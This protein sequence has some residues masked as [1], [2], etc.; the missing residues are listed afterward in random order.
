M[1][2]TLLYA[3]LLLQATETRLLQQPPA[4]TPKPPVDWV[5]FV[6][7]PVYQPDGGLSAET[8]ALPATG[9]GLVHL[10]SRRSVCEPSASSTAEPKDAAFGWRIAS[11]ILSRTERDV[12]VSINWRRLWEDGRKVN[13]GPGSTV[14]LTLH[15]G[16]RIPL[17]HIA[18]V[19]PVPECRAVGLGLE[20]R[21]AQAAGATGVAIPAFPPDATPGGTKP[22]DAEL[23]LLHTSPSD[24]Q[25][26]FHQ[27]VRIPT[28]GGRFSF[29]P[30]TITSA[31]G[32]ASV[33]LSGSI[34]RYR[35]TTGEE[36][37]LLS[38]TRRVRGY[39]LP[40]EGVPTSTRPA[41]T[42][43]PPP[44]EVISFQ[45]PGTA[46]GRVIAG[47][48]DPTSVAR[49]ASGAAGGVQTRGGGGGAGSAVGPATQA[50][51]AALLE[52]HQLALRL[53]VTQVN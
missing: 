15:V 36:Y 18:N 9:P 28:E 43:L 41:R 44:T 37:L 6:A 26:V 49:S 40:P 34:D 1:I 16:A 48:G 11:Q 17:D 22:I 10:Y 29:A 31:R 3:T 53:R 30:T 23:W 13:N 33:E 50:Q 45:M 51:V 42:P 35:T 46:P 2:L 27:T 21:V 32:E 39:G 47:T 5:V 19:K 4:P 20:V 38:L 25:Q 14:Q 52:G 8:V 24:V 12:V 7:A